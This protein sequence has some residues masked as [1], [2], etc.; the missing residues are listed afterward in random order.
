MVYSPWGHKK[1]D[2]TEQ[3]TVM[4]LY[5]FIHSYADEHLDCFYVLV[6]INNVAM[7]TGV[8]ISFQLKVCTQDLKGWLIK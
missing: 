1:L 6:I 2:S 8:H 7:N 3:L 4:C 5:I